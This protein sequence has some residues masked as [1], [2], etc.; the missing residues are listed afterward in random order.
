MDPFLLVFIIIL[1]YV[2]LLFIIQYLGIGS[3]KRDSNSNN[4][5]PDCSSTLNRVNRIFKDKI[6]YY[7]TLGMFNWKRYLCGKC[8][9]KGLRWTK[10]YK[11]KGN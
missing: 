10:Q 8:E 6:I 1:L 4:C 5:C 7:L 2:L 9:W 11:P 3:K